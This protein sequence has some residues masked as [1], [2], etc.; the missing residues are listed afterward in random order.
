MFY[1]VNKA[2]LLCYVDD[3]SWEIM[4]L[5]TI[6]LLYTWKP[7]NRSDLLRILFQLEKSERSFK[8]PKYMLCKQTLLPLQRGTLST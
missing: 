3:R 6:I 1:G 8:A 4:S 7:G 2:A 5:N